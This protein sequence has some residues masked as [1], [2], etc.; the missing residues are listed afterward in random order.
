MLYC[1]SHLYCE[2]VI[3]MV[4]IVEFVSFYSSFILNSCIFMLEIRSQD[5]FFLSS[6]INKHQPILYDVFVT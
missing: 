1:I 3:C 2:L 4:Y 6:D 5:D